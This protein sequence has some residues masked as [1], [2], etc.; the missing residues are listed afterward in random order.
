M[1]NVKCK[2]YGECEVHTCF[3]VVCVRIYCCC[4]IAVVFT[5]DGVVV[6]LFATVLLFVCLRRFDCWFGC[7]GGGV[8]L[9]AVLGCVDG[10]MD[11]C[12]CKVRGKCEV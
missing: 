12:V 8:V 3:L 6:G 4:D 11:T 9:V 1:A 7:G 2:V 5:V 10:L